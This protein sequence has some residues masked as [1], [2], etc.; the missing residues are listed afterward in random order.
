MCLR[1][2]YDAPIVVSGRIYDVTGLCVE[3]SERRRMLL[4]VTYE[5]QSRDCEDYL[6]FRFYI[7]GNAWNRVMADEHMDPIMR[8][9]RRWVRTYLAGHPGKVPESRGGE[10]VPVYVRLTQVYEPGR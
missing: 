3:P 2:S 10:I 7:R 4:R 1:P 6:P 5:V 9:V 8:Y